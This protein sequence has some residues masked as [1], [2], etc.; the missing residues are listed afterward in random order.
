MRKMTVRRKDQ[1]DESNEG[2]PDGS[3]GEIKSHLGKNRRKCPTMIWNRAELR[4]ERHAMGIC[5]RR[6]GRTVEISILR[7]TQRPRVAARLTYSEVP[8]QVQERAQSRSSVAIKTDF[9]EGN[10]SSAVVEV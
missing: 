10:R 6:N 2:S 8:K 3:W 1:V 5:R 9:P 4:K 7:M